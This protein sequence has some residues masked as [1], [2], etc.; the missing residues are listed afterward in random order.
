MSSE[1]MTTTCSR[2]GRGT[3]SPTSDGCTNSGFSLMNP[4]TT[5]SASRSRTLTV[6]DAGGRPS[7][8][9][10]HSSPTLL[11]P[12]ICS[13]PTRR[14]RATARHP[15]AT[16]R[17]PSRP[18]RIRPPT[19]LVGRDYGGQPRDVLP[20]QAASAGGRDDQVEVLA[21]GRD[22]GGLL[23]GDGVD[24]RRALGAVGG[25]AD[26]ERDPR[27]GPVVAFLLV[28]RREFVV[29]DLVERPPDGLAGRGNDV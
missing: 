22:L 19:A 1:I 23:R 10:R 7:R 18:A 16:A 24:E 11:I 4:A 5:S 28:D 17:R 3:V 25:R 26:G 14:L 8:A 12:P 27:V 6:A 20:G 2:C 9:W 29:A 15:G 21:R 13:R